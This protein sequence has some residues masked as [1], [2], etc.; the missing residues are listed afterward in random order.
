MPENIDRTKVLRFFSWTSRELGLI[1]GAAGC[2]ATASWITY[3]GVSIAL[4]KAE[5]AWILGYTAAGAAVLLALAAFLIVKA[6]TN[7]K[8]L[9]D[10]HGELSRVK[11]NDFA[12]VLVQSFHRTGAALSALRDFD[13][14][15]P[16]TQ[17]PEA[18]G[19]EN[20]QLLEALA[21]KAVFLHSQQGDSE[22]LKFY[23]D[24][25][26]LV[27]EHSPISVAVLYLSDEE[28][29]AYIATA[30][31]VRGTV[32]GEELRRIPLRK[33]I[34]VRAE[35]VC[36]SSGRAENER[37]FQEYERIIRN[38]PSNVVTSVAQRM[39]ICVAG[40][41]DFVLPASPPDYW[42]GRRPGAQAG[43]NERFARIASEI[44]RRARIARAGTESGLHPEM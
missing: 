21:T 16:L 4:M 42:H 19:P 33:V 34:D 41:E 3:L 7:D 20:E 23:F 8:R 14:A 13:Q 15:D 26:S 39:R 44:A 27:F 10:W 38:N 11:R 5:K 35:P 2:M 25:S 40:N 43:E 30:D 31:I 6:L 17:S 29:I 22:Y 12:R 32:A 9:S 36:R 1:L 28:L 37:L 24:G 18:A